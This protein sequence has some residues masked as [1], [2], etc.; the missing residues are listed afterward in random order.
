VAACVD[1][2][3]ALAVDPHRSRRHDGPLKASALSDHRHLRAR[4]VAHANLLGLDWS[5]PAISS[6]A[7][8]PILVPVFASPEH[9]ARLDDPPVPCKGLL[10]G[11][12]LLIREVVDAGAVLDPL[13]VAPGVL[14]SIDR[15]DHNAV[16]AA[17]QDSSRER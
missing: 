14:P 17:V 6:I 15:G 4:P 13:R 10:D 7:I 8:G 11:L 16:A 9:S 5:M 1:V 12:P 2:R 3:L